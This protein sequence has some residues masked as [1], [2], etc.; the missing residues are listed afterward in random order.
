VC[1]EAAATQRRDRQVARLVVAELTITCSR[2]IELPPDR[3][4]QLEVAA[5]TEFDRFSI[6][7]ET[8]WAAPE[9]SFLA[10]EGAELAAFYNL[11]ERTVRIDGVPVRVAGL[12]NLVTLPAYRGR[13]IASRLLRDTR[14][15]WFD[16]IGA[17]CG[18]L[19]CADALVPFYSRLDW[20][21]VRVRV[22]Y[23]QPDGS[24]TWAA[25]C[26]LLDPFRKLATARD[27]DLC[28]LP[29]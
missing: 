5:Q 13:G 29:W 28:G 16:V 18:L 21:N 6:V 24:R 9:W 22:S 10:F 3:R 23:A 15:R 4:H 1:R 11:V 12:N 19:L 8:Q 26:M 20:Q 17:E 2:R 25:N 27:I 7:R 14:P